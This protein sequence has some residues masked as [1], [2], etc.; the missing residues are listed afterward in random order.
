M[1]K[2]SFSGILLWLGCLLF[3]Q[4]LYSDESSVE[5]KIKAGY[6]YNFTKFVTWPNDGLETFN[7]CVVGDDPFG[8]SIDPIEQR[9]ALGRPIKLIRLESIDAL[10]GDNKDRHCHILF[11]SSS[12]KASAF[13]KGSLVIRDI[14]KTLTVGESEAFARQ[15][16]MIGFVKK[17]DKIKLQI[18]LGLIKQSSLKVS[19][20]LLEVAELIDGKGIDGGQQ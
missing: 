3:S 9:T 15:G 20:K 1:T 10:K 2:N 4:V 13:V 5:Y 11:V 14:D 18:N 7:L 8:E 17:G 6:L 16:G 12:I 19:A